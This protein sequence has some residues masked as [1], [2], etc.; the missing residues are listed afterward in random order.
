MNLRKIIKK[1]R[2]KL[3]MIKIYVICLFINIIIMISK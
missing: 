2:K 1:L 3:F